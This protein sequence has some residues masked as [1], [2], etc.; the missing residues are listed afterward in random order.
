VSLRKKLS[1]LS[2]ESFPKKPPVTFHTLRHQFGE[3]IKASDISSDEGASMMGHQ[4]VESINRYEDKCT[5]SGSFKVTAVI[6]S[7]TL[8]QK[9]RNSLGPR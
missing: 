5:G 3:N 7:S 6:I 9:N 1:R 2:K 8:R 4:F